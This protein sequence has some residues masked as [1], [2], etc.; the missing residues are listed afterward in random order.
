MNM[1]A[2]LAAAAVVAVLFILMRNKVTKGSSCCGEHESPVERIRA[3]DP[4]PAH[5]PYHYR[6]F[7]EGMVCANCAKRVENAFLGTGEMLANVDLGRKEVDLLSK[8]ELDR[9]GAAGIVDRAGY[10]LTEFEKRGGESEKS[11]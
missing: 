6:L 8:R 3:D 11:L 7:V 10:T 4:D 2:I 9:R 5:Y 1:L